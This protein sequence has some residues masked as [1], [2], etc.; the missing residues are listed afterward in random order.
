L[1]SRWRKRKGVTGYRVTGLQ[2]TG[3]RLQGCR[4][5]VVQSF[6]NE[7]F[8]K[9][10]NPAHTDTDGKAV[11]KIDIFSP[12]IFGFSKKMYLCDPILKYTTISDRYS[13][14]TYI[15]TIPPR[16]QKQTWIS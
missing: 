4:F 7:I 11:K 6:E 5:G 14:E 15:S 13:N 2:V 10:H 3:Y 9:K 12:N 8:I 16:P 1:A